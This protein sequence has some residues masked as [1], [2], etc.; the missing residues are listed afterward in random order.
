MIVE[1]KNLDYILKEFNLESSNS[2]TFNK[3]GKN[4]N[5]KTINNLPAELIKYAFNINEAEPTIIIEH[6]DNYFIVEL[7]KTE[8]VQRKIHQ[9][10]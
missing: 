9:N 6:K 1:G 10:C 3:L 7:T 2:T 5:S 8:N 4:K